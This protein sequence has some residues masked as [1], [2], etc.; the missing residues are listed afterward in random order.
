MTGITSGTL[1]GMIV[2]DQILGKQNPFSDVRSSCHPMKLMHVLEE[3]LSL[4]TRHAIL[5]SQ[6]VL[7]GR[8]LHI[9]NVVGLVMLQ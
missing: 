6:A 4:Y 9:S 8:H 7:L 5:A 2:A 3:E 1:A